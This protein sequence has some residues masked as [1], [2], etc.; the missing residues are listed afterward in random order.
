METKLYEG[1]RRK[2]ATSVIRKFCETRLD[3]VGNEFTQKKVRES[4]NMKIN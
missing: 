1:P 2:R 3:L 4:R